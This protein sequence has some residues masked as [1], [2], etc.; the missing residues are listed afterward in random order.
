MTNLEN[1]VKNTVDALE[2]FYFIDSIDYIED[3]AYLI[4]NTPSYE[5]YIVIDT[6]DKYHVS[7]LNTSKNDIEYKNHKHIKNIK[8]LINY[9]DKFTK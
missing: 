9:I 8:T 3:Y 1:K 2:R 5:I 7:T 6:D 4:I